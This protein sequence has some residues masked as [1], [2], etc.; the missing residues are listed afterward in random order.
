MGMTELYRKFGWKHEFD[1]YDEQS[2]ANLR[3]AFVMALG[4]S[5]QR[6]FA[7]GQ[8]KAFKGIDKAL[9]RKD[10]DLNRQKEELGWKKDMLAVDKTHLNLIAEVTLVPDALERLNKTFRDVGWKAP[11][12]AFSLESSTEKR[13]ALLETLDGNDKV[14]FQKRHDS[15]VREYRAAYK[16]EEDFVQK[17]ADRADE[18]NATPDH[19][20]LG[21][22]YS[23]LSQFQREAL[24]EMAKLIQ[25]DMFWMIAEH[26]R[27]IAITTGKARGRN[28]P[29]EHERDIK[30]PCGPAVHLWVRDQCHTYF[31]S[32]ALMESLEDVEI[33]GDYSLTEVQWPMEGFAIVLPKPILTQFSYN[34][35]G[36]VINREVTG[37][38]MGLPKEPEIQHGTASVYK[39]FRWDDLPPPPFQTIK[40]EVGKP[41]ITL[42]CKDTYGNVT[43]ADMLDG[44]TKSF[45]FA[46]LF[47]AM[48]KPE[49]IT[50]GQRISAPPGKNAKRGEVPTWTPNYLG[51]DYVI[52][53]RS[54][55]GSTGVDGRK[56]RRKRKSHM[57]MQPYGPQRSLRKRIW[58]EAYWAGSLEL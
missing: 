4:P 29:G 34:T 39:R 54:G 20:I 49:L 38:I 53:D 25:G 33:E 41:T 23:G 18:M 48:S 42:I 58:V 16:I 9:D 5:D 21:R 6:R 40:T 51:R 46:I 12:E 2:N 14:I 26:Y 22:K 44:P 52:P 55:E 13:I 50:K 32:E 45:M 30:D 7:D 24:Q 57:K 37:F 8:Y 47:A 31:I 28:K 56:V 19:W 3:V 17:V 27:N 35:S 11:Y 43:D 10:R 15:M 1:P 36:K